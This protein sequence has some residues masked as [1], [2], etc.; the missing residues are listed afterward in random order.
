[1]KK[2]IFLILII[3]TL[4]NKSN[5]AEL[6]SN[7]SAF[8]DKFSTG[9]VVLECDTMTNIFCAGK[10]GFNQL[11][12]YKLY[13]SG[14]WLNL[15]KRVA[16]LNSANMLGYFYLSKSAYML[17]YYDASLNYLKLAKERIYSKDC[18]LKT[19]SE[20]NLNAEM[21]ELESQ[22]AQ[23]NNNSQTVATNNSTVKKD[24]STKETSTE[25]DQIFKEKFSA[26]Q[27]SL[28]CEDSICASKWTANRS[29]LIQLYKNSDWLN[30]AKSVADLNTPN[31]LSYFYLTKSAYMLGYYDAS[32]KYWNLTQRRPYKECKFNACSEV[33]FDFQMSEL[34][35][36]LNE[37]IRKG[38]IEIKSTES[39]SQKFGLK[40]DG[41][42]K[43]FGGVCVGSYTGNIG[44]VDP[45]GLNVS[46]DKLTFDKYQK[47]MGPF[48]IVKVSKKVG[49][50]CDFIIPNIVRFNSTDEDVLYVELHQCDGG[51]F[52]EG[53]LKIT[54]LV[55]WKYGNSMQIGEL[56]ATYFG[57]AGNSLDNGPFLNALVQRYG[58]KNCEKQTDQMYCRL[59]NEM[60]SIGKYRSGFEAQLMSTL[61]N[62]G[63]GIALFN[64]HIWNPEIGK[65]ATAEAQSRKV[66]KVK[67]ELQAPVNKF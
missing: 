29:N 7:D 51:V 14:D 11:S 50:D 32:V 20:F 38:A 46:H 39:N 16:D 6:D 5:S 31:I 3:F 58:T 1:M 21:Q 22:L 25:I 53:L 13:Q 18:G 48:G 43:I 61:P 62:G 47:L 26:G 15:A 36:R 17:G 42:E 30:L 28:G 34:R 9:K 67:Q 35:F 55:L 44:W 64:V 59:D 24:I 63:K 52:D 2:I 10:W 23:Q 4:N 40:C 66:E 19:C 37:L 41:A 12:A 54:D 65:K 49:F 56:Y 27:V 45:G 33:N 57:N 60:I 8:S